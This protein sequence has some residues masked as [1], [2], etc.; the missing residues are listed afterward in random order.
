MFGTSTKEMKAMIVMTTCMSQ[1]N[2][3]TMVSQ[4]NDKMKK[5]MQRNMNE[6]NN[7]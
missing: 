4:P 1:P 5:W 3:K 6:P 7:E 2:N